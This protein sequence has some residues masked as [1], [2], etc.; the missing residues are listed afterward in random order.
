MEILNAQ[1]PGLAAESVL[2]DAY[3]NPTTLHCVDLIFTFAG[4]PGK[5]KGAAFLGLAHFQTRT[6]VLNR[7]SR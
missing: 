2:P 1:T 3:Q 4:L 6:A 7:A 5:E